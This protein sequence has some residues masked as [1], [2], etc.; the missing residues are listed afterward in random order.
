MPT[1]IPVPLPSWRIAFSLGCLLSALL[2]LIQALLV[3]RAQ[4]GGRWLHVF[5]GGPPV[6]APRGYG[7]FG[8]P[9]LAWSEALLFAA[10]VLNFYVLE[11]WATYASPYFVY[12]QS[13][14]VMLP[15]PPVSWLPAWFQAMIDP[16]SAATRACAD[17]A[18]QILETHRARTI[19]I[20]IPLMEGT[21]AYVALHATRL[22]G[23]TYWSRPFLAG[24]AV[25]SLDALLDPVV[26]DA[27]R[28]DV[29]E[30]RTFGLGLWRWFTEPAAMGQWYGIPLFNFGAWYAS[31]IISVGV[32]GMVSSLWR[33]LHRRWQIRNGLPADP[34]SHR[35]FEPLVWAGILVAAILVKWLNPTER[36]DHPGWLF[37][38]QAAFVS[39]L[40]L[41][42]FIAGLGLARRRSCNRP[43][44]AL[45]VPPM[46]FLT[47]P[48]VVR[49]AVGPPPGST[50]GWITPWTAVLLFAFGVFLVVYPYWRRLVPW[51]R[52]SCA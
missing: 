7:S 2:V 46:F 47:Y 31:A 37:S 13:F 51:S 19:P 10:F 44:L 23:A 14:A 21:I 38:P 12:A 24:M 39:A 28:C 5:F 11:T 48:L 4:S 40:V 3:R 32:P 17:V 50:L 36:T 25:V 49:F 43:R 9:T 20:E 22:V 34:P 35:P 27:F 16:P 8:P 15:T 30:A 45:I 33:T 42:G 29:P 52:R 6:I 18:T 1:D 41:T 26:S